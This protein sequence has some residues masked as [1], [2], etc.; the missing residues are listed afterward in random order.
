[1]VGMA[2]DELPA[3]L[4]DEVVRGLIVDLNTAVALHAGAVAR[5]GKAI[6]VPGATG[7]GKSSLIAW[8][9]D[10]AFDYLTDEITL[11]LNAGANILGLPRAMVIKSGAD[12][13]VMQLSAFAGAAPISSAAQLILGA[14]GAVPKRG[15]ISCGLIVFPQF[16]EG[17]ELRIEPLSTAAAAVRLIGCNLNARNLP[18]GGFAA[19]SR[20]ARSAPAVTLVYGGYEQL[21]GV[22][23]T[24]AHTVL[25][26]DRDPG[27]MRRF[28]LAF[29]GARERAPPQKVERFPVPPATPRRQVAP[30]LTLG[31]A[32]YDDYDGVYFTL[33]GIRLYHSEILPDVEFVVVDNHPDGPCS[34]YLKALEN[35]VAN[36]RYVPFGQWSGSTVRELVF[37]EAQAD[38]VLCMDCHVFIVPGALKR[39]LGYLE[40]HPDTKDLLQGP[41]L[42]DD[43]SRTATHFQPEWRSGM[44]GHWTADERGIDPDAP[45]FDIPMQGLGLFACRRA[46]WPGFNPRFRGFGGE[47]G[48]IHEKFRRN[49]GRTLCLPFLRWVHRF[50]RPM[51]TRYVN[52]WEDRMRNYMLGFHELG[53]A[54]DVVERHFVEHLG[55][56]VA[57]PILNRIREELAEQPVS[58]VREPMRQA[59]RLRG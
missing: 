38:F 33:Q 41:L 17:A 1:V 27:Q 21:E 24:L 44:W 12:K 2:R 10:R 15:P 37:E 49:G 23:D 6:L 48:Y 26:S 40:A 5:N 19:I 14:P 55:E 53:L 4:M 7:S 52:T 59:V 30:R 16:S 3:F 28:L 43:L 46:A 51:G 58:E 57:R 47:E 22:V 13:S 29:S 11:L 25:N 39:L 50:N 35:S 34:K 45:P 54:T 20:L 32:T 18:D 8:L 31:M 9:I 42:D 36:Y 56:T